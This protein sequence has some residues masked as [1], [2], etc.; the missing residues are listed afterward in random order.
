MFCPSCRDEFRPGFTRCERCQEDLVDDLSQVESDRAAAPAPAPRESVAM[1]DYC[2]FFSLE[3][4]AQ[5]RALL[6]RHRI[7][8]EIV[9][10]EPPDLDWD[11]P[12][13]DEF[14]LRVDASRGREV[15]KLVDTPQPEAP[16]AGETFAC[17]ECGHDVAEAE[18][19]CPSCGAR[20]DD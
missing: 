15:Q 12:P 17:S 10:R 7:R 13:K 6:R 18:S 8:T 2:G 4:A 3:E 19:F 20:F 5:A 14:W 9:L 16:S 11:A 1:I